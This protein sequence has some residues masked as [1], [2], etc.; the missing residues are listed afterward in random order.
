MFKHPVFSMIINNNNWI[1]CSLWANW[2]NIYIA[3]NSWCC[4]IKM[5]Q[6]QPISI[7]LT[8]GSPPLVLEAQLWE[9]HF[10]FQCL[11][12][13]GRWVG[14]AC[15]LAGRIYAPFYRISEKIFLESLKHTC[16]PCEDVISG[17]WNFIWYH[18]RALWP[19]CIHNGARHKTETLVSSYKSALEM[20][21]LL[22][23]TS[24][25]LEAFERFFCRNIP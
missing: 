24:V 14:W 21:A 7:G 3:G 12:V 10:D 18:L 6:A 1:S 16:S 5:P 25:E 9:L 11:F 15:C 8:S 17:I 2:L 22:L 23:G 19:I 4:R 13:F 20:R